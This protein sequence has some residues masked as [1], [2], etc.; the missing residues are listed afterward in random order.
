MRATCKDCTVKH[1]SQA[2]VL[3]QEAQN[4]YPMHEVYAIGHLAEAE[5]ECPSDEHRRKI[6]DLRINHEWEGLDALLMEIACS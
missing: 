3:L 4:G 5:A 1:L 2:L 6:R